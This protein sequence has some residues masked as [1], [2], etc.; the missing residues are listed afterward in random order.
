MCTYN[1]MYIFIHIYIYIHIY[2]I[3]VCVHAGPPAAASHQES[4]GIVDIKAEA[5]H[6]LLIL[7]RGMSRMWMSYVTCECIMSDSTLQESLLFKLKQLCCSCSVCCSVC[8]SVL[9]CLLQCVSVCVAFAVESPGILDVKAGTRH[10]LC[11]CVC[12]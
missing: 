2:K 7:Y 9:Q 11:V 4:P 8:C 3:Y 1:S 6:L 12:L 5:G 10:R